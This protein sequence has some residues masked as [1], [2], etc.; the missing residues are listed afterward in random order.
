MN[1]NNEKVIFIDHQK[2]FDT[3]IPCIF[4]SLYNPL[5]CKMLRTRTN[6]WWPLIDITQPETRKIFVSWTKFSKAH[7]F[8]NVDDFLSLLKVYVMLVRVNY[9]FK[10]NLYFP[11]GPISEVWKYL[12]KMG[13]KG[14]RGGLSLWFVS[15][16]IVQF[17]ENLNT[18]E[19]LIWDKYCSDQ[20]RYQS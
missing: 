1:K 11:R 4:F 10:I 2:Y 8:Q 3:D 6:L 20:S 14:A 19:T 9:R 15:K 12:W 16:I 18:Y 7:Q 13:K 17:W 5:V